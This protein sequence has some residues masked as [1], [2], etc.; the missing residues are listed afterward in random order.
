MHAVVQRVLHASVAVEGRVVGQI[1][2]GL[3]VLV[4]VRVGDGPA[5]ADWLAGKLV[6]LRIFPNEAG[7]FDR[8]VRDVAGAILLVPNFT[9][10]GDARKG[11]RPDFTAAA[12]PEH[13]KPLF[14][15][16]VASV[17]AQGVPAATGEFGASMAVTLL[18]DGPVTILLD[19]RA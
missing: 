2:R 16:V 8:S 14:D 18:N 5:D 17:I 13:A 10:A 1:D 11:N 3:M 15:A 6:G 7:K 9:L 4:G 12:R 19:S